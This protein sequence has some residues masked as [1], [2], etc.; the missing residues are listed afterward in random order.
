MEQSNQ[1]SVKN[2]VVVKIFL[3]IIVQLIIAIPLYILGGMLLYGIIHVG[4]IVEAIMAVIFFLISLYLTLLILGK[5]FIPQDIRDLSK[6]MGMVY[7]AFGI[8]VLV[9]SLSMKNFNLLNIIGH[10]V[11]YPLLGYFFIRLFL[12]KKFSKQ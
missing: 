3:I 1:S 5:R 7:L 9:F 2:K 6:T 8:L 10:L 11:L 12:Q 4:S